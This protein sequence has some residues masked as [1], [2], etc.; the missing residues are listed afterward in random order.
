MS[1]PF[2]VITCAEPEM[3]FEGDQRSTAAISIYLS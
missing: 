3:I 1:F 2:E